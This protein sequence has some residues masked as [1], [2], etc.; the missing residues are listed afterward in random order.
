M[1]GDGKYE[2]DKVFLLSSSAKVAAVIMGILYASGFIV[3][4]L[5]LSQFNV[6]PFELIRVQYLISGLWLF[7]PL[8]AIAVPLFWLA[9]FLHDVY[10]APV[11]AKGPVWRQIFVDLAG[12][13]GLDQSEA[14]RILEGRVFSPQVNKDW[15]RAW[16]EG[17][18]GVPTFSAMDLYVVGCQPYEV[19]ER[20]VNHLRE[21]KTTG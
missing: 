17:V 4:S 21:L 6:R 1:S 18:T 11:P 9:G 3:V 12:K 19:L 16:Q 15:E 10:R 13:S 8:I 5:H 7:L 20:F 14:R 2:E